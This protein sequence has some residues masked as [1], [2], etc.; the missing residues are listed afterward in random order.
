[1]LV[2]SPCT[3]TDGIL[4]VNKT[5]RLPQG[6]AVGAAPRPDQQTDMLHQFLVAWMHAQHHAIAAAFALAKPTNERLMHVITSQSLRQA[7]ERKH[8]HQ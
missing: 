4:H 1:M 5:C 3:V 7:C 8:M 6:S 2:P